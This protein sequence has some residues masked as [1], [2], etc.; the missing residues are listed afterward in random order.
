M[1]FKH[2]EGYVQMSAIPFSGLYDPIPNQDEYLLRIGFCGDAKN[3]LKTLSS[4][5]RAHMQSVPFE[6]LE[7]YFEKREPDLSTAALFEKIVMN[8]RGGYCFELNGLFSRLLSSLDFS[9]SLFFARV[10]KGEFLSPPSHEVLCVEAEGKR[11]FCDVGF[12]GPVPSSPIELIYD[13]ELRCDE[14]RIYRFEKRVGET[15]L[16][17]LRDGIFSDILIFSEAPRDAV[18]FIPLNAFCAY[19]PLEPFVHKAM[20]WKRE[21]EKR[22]SIDGDIFRDGESETKINSREE[23]FSL[24]RERFGMKI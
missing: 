20:V 3:D 19:S 1:P 16:Q 8:C 2:C 4:L 9:V 24:L 11:Y 12:G 6:N 18:D 10:V 23:L 5:M 17:I 21:G 22:I 13:R 15:A 14:G 7:V